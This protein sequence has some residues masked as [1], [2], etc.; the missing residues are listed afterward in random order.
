MSS[1]ETLQHLVTILQER[2]YLREFADYLPTL[3][4]VDG[5]IAAIN[6]GRTNDA[7]GQVQK[8]L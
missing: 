6:E 4:F 2:G 7:V 8:F 5:V 3:S 1:L